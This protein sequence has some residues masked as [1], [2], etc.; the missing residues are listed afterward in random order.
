MRRKDEIKPFR[1][2]VTP[3]GIVPHYNFTELTKRNPPPIDHDTPVVQFP[4]GYFKN[5]CW[6]AK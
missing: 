1:W 2:T 3:S 4:L 6:L 5:G